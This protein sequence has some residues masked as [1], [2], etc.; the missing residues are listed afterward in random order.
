MST[1]RIPKRYLDTSLNVY[2]KSQAKDAVGEVTETLV[3][4][5]QEVPG[6]IQPRTSEIEHR[7]GGVSHRQ[8]H[9]CHINR[10]SDG[11]VQKEIEPLDLLADLGTGKR[12]TILSIEER[13]MF[14]ETQGTH[15][16][17][18]LQH[19]SDERFE[20]FFRRDI[21]SKARIE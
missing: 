11:G 10:F 8:T 21:T 1:T 12:Y 15:F 20:T 7:L 14:Q 2:G 16:M 3:P 9:V 18:T 19:L 5:Y 6:N 4:K 13:Q 17:I